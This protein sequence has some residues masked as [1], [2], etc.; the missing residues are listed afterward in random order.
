MVGVL[1]NG[2]ACD[3][4][5][6]PL[7]RDPH[8]AKCAMCGAPGAPGLFVKTSSMDERVWGVGVLRLRVSFAS[9]NSH[10]AQDDSV[11]LCSEHG[12]HHTRPISPSSFPRAR[13]LP[14]PAATDLWCGW[15]S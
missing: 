15:R 12:G 4:D 9:R 13:A 6:F 11:D 3:L 14:G 1:A 2:V 10:S 5:A 8:I 7:L